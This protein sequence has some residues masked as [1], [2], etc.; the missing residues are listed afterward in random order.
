M[1]AA[2]LA[3]GSVSACMSQ[4]CTLCIE[5]QCVQGWILVQL[6]QSMSGCRYWY[7]TR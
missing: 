6:V 4:H 1:P 2:M 5:W 7:V 3:L